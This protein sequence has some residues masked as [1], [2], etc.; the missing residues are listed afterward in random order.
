MFRI[1]SFYFALLH[2]LYNFYHFSPGKITIKRVSW[3]MK[4]RKPITKAADYD[5]ELW[6]NAMNQFGTLNDLCELGTGV[7]LPIDKFPEYNIISTIFRYNDTRYTGVHMSNGDAI[8]PFTGISMSQH[9]WDEFV[10]RLPE[11][12]ELSKG[13]TQERD[14][15]KRKHDSVQ[16]L[17]QIKVYTWEWI[18]AGNVFRESGEEVYYSEEDARDYAMKREPVAGLTYPTQSGAPTLLVQEKF[19]DVI[20]I[21]EHVMLCYLTMLES[22]IE[23]LKEDSCT[24]CAVK[25]IDSLSAHTHEGN[26]MDDTCA[27]IDLHF[28]NAKKD[29]NIRKL[30]SVFTISRRGMTPKIPSVIQAAET[31]LSI[32]PGWFLKSTIG[33]AAD[34]DATRSLKRLIIK[35][36]KRVNGCMRPEKLFS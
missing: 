33:E 11:I 14:S 26:C 25:E 31:V 12:I 1:A 23:V 35:A 18:V 36:D 5:V 10:D 15:L 13:K 19:A 22:R 2:F 3:D 16:G 6:E 21:P 24:A 28:E 17:N 4:Q 7:Q 30:I 29:V 9:E 34:K 20:A 27:H 32:L 8:I